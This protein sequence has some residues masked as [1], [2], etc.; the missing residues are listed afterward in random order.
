MYVCMCICAYVL[1]CVDA[2]LVKSDYE[3]LKG[4]CMYVCVYV[5]VCVDAVLAKSD[6]ESSKW[7]MYACVCMCISCM[8]TCNSRCSALNVLR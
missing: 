7:C 8:C 5:L 3:T 1:V 4:V 2:V 6:Y